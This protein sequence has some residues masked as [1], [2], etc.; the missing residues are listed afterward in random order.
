[1]HL[2]EQHEK[3]IDIL[4]QEFKKNL[5]RVQEKYEA[6][7][8]ESDQLKMMNE[9]KLTMQEEEQEDEITAVNER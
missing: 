6:S 1:M 5:S 8:K 3:A 7:K 4:L 2:N 9:E